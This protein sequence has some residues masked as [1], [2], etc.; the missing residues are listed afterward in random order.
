MFDTISNT[1]IKTM[2][3]SSRSLLGKSEEEIRSINTKILNQLINNLIELKTK[4]DEL[5][6]I[7][8]R[9]SVGRNI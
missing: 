8:F 5:N 2:E 4:Q 9:R 6:N 1:L 3:E 7:G